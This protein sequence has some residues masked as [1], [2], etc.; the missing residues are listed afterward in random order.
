[1]GN[2]LFMVR[3]ARKGALLT[4]RTESRFNTNMPYPYLNTGSSRSMAGN[5]FFSDQ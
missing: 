2:N 5:S 1:M 4:M 3:D